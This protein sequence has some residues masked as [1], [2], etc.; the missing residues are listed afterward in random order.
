MARGRSGAEDVL[1]VGDEVLVVDGKPVEAHSDRDSGRLRDLFLG[2][3]GTVCSLTLQ[4]G[5][6]RMQCSVTRPMM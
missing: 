1:Q 6:D 3:P 2:P 5:A 4:R